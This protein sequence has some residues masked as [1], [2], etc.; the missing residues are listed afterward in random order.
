MIASLYQICL[1]H[2]ASKIQNKTDV[3]TELHKDIFHH[4]KPKQKIKVF[5]QYKEWYDEEKTQLFKC[6]NYN[7]RGQLDGV[8]A[9]YFKSGHLWK[10][11][12]CE[13]GRY[14][15]NC[16]VWWGKT[17]QHIQCNYRKGK[18]HGEYKQWWYNGTLHKCCHY[19]YGELQGE[20][21]EYDLNGDLIPR[22]LYKSIWVDYGCL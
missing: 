5:Q 20:Y 9:Q 16:E 19:H 12:Y 18:L 2:A 11:V 3:P 14:H 21:R 13:N 8:S 17:D 7:E 10:L 1:P 4:M 15:G 6:F 22:C